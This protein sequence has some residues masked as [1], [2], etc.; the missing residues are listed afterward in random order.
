MTLKVKYSMVVVT[1]CI[2][3]SMG[4]AGVLAQDHGGYG[5]YFGTDY[6]LGGETISIWEYS[7][8]AYG[9]FNENQAGYGRIEE[10]EELFNCNIELKSAAQTELYD[11]YMNRLLAGESNYDIWHTITTYYWNLVTQGALYAVDDVLPDAYYDR[12]PS[13]IRKVIEVQS[14]MGKRYGFAPD[15][16]YG[17]I[18][19]GGFF[20]LWYNKDILEREGVE[21]PYQT[22]LDGDWTW[23]AYEEMARKL[24]KDLDG[25]GTIDQYG[26]SNPMW[27]VTQAWL[28]S[29]GGDVTA[30]NDDG[31]VELV[32]DSEANRQTMNQLY[33]WVNVDN[34]VGLPGME[35]KFM[36]QSCATFAGQLWWIH[37]FTNA[38]DAEVGFVPL[39][40]GPQV[41]EYKYHAWDLPN[42]VLPSNSEQPEALMALLEFL[43]R[44]DPEVAEENFMGYLQWA[45]PTREMAEAA[46]QAT[47]DWDGE[48]GYLISTSEFHGQFIRACFDVVRGN[49][50]YTEAVDSVFPQLEAK[51]DD[52]FNR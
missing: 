43:W 14:Y 27:W 26:M 17:N 9:R 16:D 30:I 29:N 10:A 46:L 42:W 40:K 13:Y 8:E 31:S 34:L 24:T 38:L 35:A 33:E 41:D 6:D 2:F 39:P 20:V 15:I 28:S 22:Y 1:L 7:M 36:D 50:T 37:N 47:E 44:D 48:T 4:A 23:E 25:D 5:G 49:L 18:Y 11:V 19:V 3:L 52:V 21:D 32:L 51:L 12:F 45:Y